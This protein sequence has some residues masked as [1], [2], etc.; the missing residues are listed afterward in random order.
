MSYGKDT[1][2]KVKMAYVS[3]QDMN[4]KVFADIR[5]KYSE[6]S[7]LRPRVIGSKGE[8]LHYFSKAGV[9]GTYQDVLNGIKSQ[10][11]EYEAVLGEDVYRMSPF[12]I[13]F[14]QSENSSVLFLGSDKQMASSLCTSVALS[15]MRQNVQV[16]LFNG[17]RTR[18]I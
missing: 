5:N 1:I 18:I 3:S 6:Y 11:G 12:R 17:D 16:H 14:S 7:Y 9:R 10:N 2:K 8:A 13:K 15:L 4:D